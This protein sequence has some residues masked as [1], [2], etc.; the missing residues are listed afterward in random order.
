MNKN[1]WSYD[2]TFGLYMYIH[3]KN[4]QST[5][6]DP[7]LD[8]YIIYRYIHTSDT[9]SKRCFQIIVIVRIHFLLKV[10]CTKYVHA[11]IHTYYKH[12]SCIHIYINQ[13][14]HSYI[15]TNVHPDRKEILGAKK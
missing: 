2:T 5:Y 8:M 11:Y 13:Y 6:N 3:T 1:G 9:T 4:L 14:I 12:T 15:G 10:Y 7:K